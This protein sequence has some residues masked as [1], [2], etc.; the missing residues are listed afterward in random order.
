MWWPPKQK[1]VNSRQIRCQESRRRE[2]VVRDT[3]HWR[4]HW[5]NWTKYEFRDQCWEKLDHHH[6]RLL[7]CWHKYVYMTYDIL[8]FCIPMISVSVLIMMK[9]NHRRNYKCS[10]EGTAGDYTVCREERGCPIGLVWY[11]WW[12]LTMR[13]L[14]EKV[15]PVAK[16]SPLNEW[17]RGFQ[18]NEVKLFV[19]SLFS[20]QRREE[21]RIL[22]DV[23]LV[24]VV[25]P[26]LWSFDFT[27]S[28][29]TVDF[30]CM[31]I[32]TRE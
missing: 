16:K 1:Q 32:E 29:F 12:E 5:T 8:I 31:C 17:Q 23:F 27:S 10:G 15:I 24:A 3:F 13:D 6:T 21:P 11:A 20:D 19:F 18:E 30:L 7:F 14:L 28:P 9:M 26:S 22:F 2:E 4:F 25:V